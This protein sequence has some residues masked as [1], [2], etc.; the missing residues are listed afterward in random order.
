LEIRKNC[1][2]NCPVG[3]GWFA[4]TLYIDCGTALFLPKLTIAMFAPRPCRYTLHFYLALNTF[5]L[6]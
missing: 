5:N 3:T 2:P 1:L 6:I 4:L